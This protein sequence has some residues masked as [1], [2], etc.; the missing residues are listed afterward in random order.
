MKIRLQL[1]VHLTSGIT[2]LK[3]IFGFYYTTCCDSCIARDNI[4]TQDN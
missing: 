2:P 4:A 3:V 1:S